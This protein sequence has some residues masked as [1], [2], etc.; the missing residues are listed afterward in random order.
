MKRPWRRV[1]RAEEFYSQL[2]FHEARGK[3]DDLVP[4]W[5]L[6]LEC[7]HHAEVSKRRW[8]YH[9]KRWRCHICQGKK[10]GK[11]DLPL[12]AAAGRGVG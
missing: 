7:G 5:R 1:R 2:A 11:F 9:P 6:R 3:K 10:I 8:R 4:M 12:V